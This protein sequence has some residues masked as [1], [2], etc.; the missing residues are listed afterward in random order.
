VDQE[1]DR[2]AEVLRAHLDVPAIYRLLEG[3]E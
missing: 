3:K 2:W 1:L